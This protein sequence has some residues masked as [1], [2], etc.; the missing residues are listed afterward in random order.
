MNMNS[1]SVSAAKGNPFVLI[2]FTQKLG[3]PKFVQVARLPAPSHHMLGHAIRVSPVNE[4][5]AAK[6]Q[7]I[8]AAFSIRPACA[9]CSS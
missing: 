1:S 2:F 8:A 6:H 4:T 9:L 5:T 3:G 7:A